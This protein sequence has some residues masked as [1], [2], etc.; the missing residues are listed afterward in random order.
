MKI[1]QKVNS[2]IVHSFFTNIW[3]QRVEEKSKLSSVRMNTLN[4]TDE[5]KHLQARVSHFPGIFS[6][7]SRVLSQFSKARTKARSQKRFSVYSSAISITLMQQLNSVGRLI[8]CLSFCCCDE[9]YSD[10]LF[11]LKNFY[12]IKRR[13]SFVLKLTPNHYDISRL[14]ILI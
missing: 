5:T 10:S 13:I 4:L 2:F 7:N 11:L 6:L 9:K 3:I 8:L 12:V 1:S 14:S